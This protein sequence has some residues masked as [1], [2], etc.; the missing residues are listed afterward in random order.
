MVEVILTLSP[1][2][3]QVKSEEKKGKRNKK[4]IK[5]ILDWGRERAPWLNKS[6]DMYTQEERIVY[7][8]WIWE[9][10]DV[11]NIAVACKGDDV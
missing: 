5:F 10:Q 6:K 9:S 1:L 2:I 4:E 8:G 3:T 11:E 7:F